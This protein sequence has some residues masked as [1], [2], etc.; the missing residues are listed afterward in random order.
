ML[1]IFSNFIDRHKKH[2]FP[3]LD[4]I[5]QNGLVVLVKILNYFKIIL[6]F[7]VMI[8]LKKKIRPINRVIEFVDKFFNIIL[9]KNKLLRFFGSFNCVVEFKKKKI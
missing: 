8:F 6:D 5:R 7:F 1:S 9:D 4:I 3:F 2:L